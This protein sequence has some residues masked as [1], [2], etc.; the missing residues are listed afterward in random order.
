MP[1]YT[2]VNAESR[3]GLLQSEQTYPLQSSLDQSRS[4][5]DSN[6]PLDSLDLDAAERSKYEQQQRWSCIP[7]RPPW[8]SGYTYEESQD[9][10]MRRPARHKGIKAVF[11][12]WKTCSIIVLILALGLIILMGSGA[13][14]VYKAVPLDGVGA[15]LVEI[16]PLAD[17]VHSYRHPGIQPLGEGLSPH[18]KRA[19]GRQKLW[20]RR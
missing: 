4:S 9:K 20:S 19:T 7:K 16:E 14:W 5:I 10:S 11:V 2:V 15:S 12:Q 18:G 13:L 6:D 1:R 8:S 3:E 17:N